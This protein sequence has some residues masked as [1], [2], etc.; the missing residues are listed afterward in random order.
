MDR[1]PGRFAARAALAPG[2]ALAQATV[3]AQTDSS[4]HRIGKR[5]PAARRFRR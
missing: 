2:L 3:L 5:N 4:R 1:P